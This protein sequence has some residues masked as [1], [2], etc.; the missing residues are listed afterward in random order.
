MV[1]VSVEMGTNGEESQ[2][3]IFISCGQGKKAGERDTAHAIA[4]RLKAL[5]FDPWIA[6][7]EQTL[8]GIKEHIFERLANSEYFLFVDFKRE[9]IGSDC[10]GSLFSHQELALASYL[11]V[12][13]IA[14]QETGVKLEGLLAF[15][16]GNATPFEDRA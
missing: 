10:R 1:V 7:E 11:G 15:L 12:D 5:G 2:A 8:R 4:E 16:G 9:Q 14:F 13:V 3:R 6:T